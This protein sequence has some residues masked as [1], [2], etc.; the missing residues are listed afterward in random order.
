MFYIAHVLVLMSEDAGC[1]GE[2][3]QNIGTILNCFSNEDIKL[4]RRIEGLEKKHITHFYAVL[5][6]EQCRKQSAPKLNRRR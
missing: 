5:L 4:V 1:A 3:L 6:N 2:T